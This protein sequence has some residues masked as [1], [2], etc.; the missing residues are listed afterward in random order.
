MLAGQFF[1][2]GQRVLL[3]VLQLDNLVFVATDEL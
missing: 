2:G 3:G 1:D